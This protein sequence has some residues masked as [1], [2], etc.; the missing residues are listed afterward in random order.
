MSTSEFGFGIVG[1][2]MIAGVVAGALARAQNARLRAV[3]S[4]QIDKARKFVAERAGVEAVE[5]H[6][7]LLRRA[8]VQGVYIAT[9]TV[10]KEAIALAA[11][12]AGKHVLVDKP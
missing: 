3:S 9:P 7:E 4:R 12:A 8:D 1:P 2:G 6:E 10:A 5:G 11:I